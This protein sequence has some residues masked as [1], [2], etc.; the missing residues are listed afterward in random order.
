MFFSNTDLDFIFSHYANGY[1]K[2]SIYINGPLGGIYHAFLVHS[3]LK[4]QSRLN[5]FKIAIA[6]S[7]T[8]Q[9]RFIDLPSSSTCIDLSYES[10]KASKPIPDYKS[11]LTFIQYVIY[12][13]LVVFPLRRRLLIKSPISLIAAG[14]LVAAGKSLS[15]YITISNSHVITWFSDHCIIAKSAIFYSPAT[16]EHTLICHGQSI[17]ETNKYISRSIFRKI[18]VSNTLQQ[19]VLSLWS[20]G[21]NVIMVK[22]S[23]KASCCLKK[24]SN[25]SL[26]ENT[27][28][29]VYLF[30]NQLDLGLANNNLISHELLKYATFCQSSDGFN[31]VVKNNEQLQIFSKRYPV[32]SFFY[33]VDDFISKV[34]CYDATC[35]VFSSGVSIDLILHNYNVLV[36]S[37]NPLMTDDMARQ[38]LDTVLHTSL[39]SGA[40][41]LYR[42]VYKSS[43]LL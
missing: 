10:L 4:R 29:N 38:V 6:L 41:N 37:Q 39:A 36:S 5:H 33:G 22:S 12:F 18:Y 13:V 2:R 35:V 1:G 7:L 32:S 14:S 20:P 34:S 43:T 28:K 9:K 8:Q 42:V 31:I 30:L 26:A 40:I 11:I 27:K 3:F 25:D 21:T 19:Q 23:S 15:E 16:V 17:G 24:I